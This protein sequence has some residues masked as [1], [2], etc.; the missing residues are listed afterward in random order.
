MLSILTNK[1]MKERN[2][3]RGQVQFQLQIYVFMPNIEH[4]TVTFS[5]F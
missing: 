5:L 2:E 3:T 4:I 1:T